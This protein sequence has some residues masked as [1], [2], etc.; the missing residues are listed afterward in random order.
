M[1]NVEM[2]ESPFSAFNEIEEQ[3]KRKRQSILIK[4]FSIII[5]LQLILLVS[6]KR[7]QK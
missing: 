1:G 4:Y 2:I 7:L 6:Q 5:R 3:R